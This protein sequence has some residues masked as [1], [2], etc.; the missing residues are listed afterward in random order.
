MNMQ[1]NNQN[2]LSFKSN[3]INRV[4]VRNAKTGELIPAVFSKLTKED[5]ES[6]EK[7][8]KNWRFPEAITIYFHFLKMSDNHNFYAIETLGE[9]NLSK[10]IIGLAETKTDAVTNDLDLKYIAIKPSLSVSGEKRRKRPIKNIGEVLF[11]TIINQAKQQHSNHLYVYSVNNAFY[12][13]IL[14]KAG[15][16]PLDCHYNNIKDDYFIKSE[17]FDKYLNY[18]SD[19]YKINFSA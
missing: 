15:I 14:K 19:N 16:S 17:Y 12:D 9:K 4:N 8:Y 3:P 6:M 18:L 1:I 5:T 7:I 13:S 2:N 10:R 11:G